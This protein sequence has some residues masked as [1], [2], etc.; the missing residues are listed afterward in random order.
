[1]ADSVARLI[2]LQDVIEIGDK[3]ARAEAYRDFLD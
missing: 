1:M 2:G 3:R